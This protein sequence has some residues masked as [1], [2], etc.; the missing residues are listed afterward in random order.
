MKSVW[1]DEWLTP[2]SWRSSAREVGAHG[3]RLHDRRAERDVRRRVLVEERVVED[4]PGLRR[5][6]SGRRRARPRRGARRRRRSR[7]AC[8]S[9]PRPSSARTSTARPPSKRTSRPRTIV[10]LD[11]ERQRRAHGALDA[12]G[13]GGREDLLGRHVRDVLD[14]A[15]TRRAPPA[16]RD[17]GCRPIVRSVPGPAV[18]EVVERAA[19]SALPR[20]AASR[21]DVLAPGGDG[22]GLVEPDRRGRPPPRAARRRARRRPSAPS[23]RSGTRRSSSC[24]GR[25]SASAT[26]R[27]PRACAPCRR[28]RRRGRRRARARGCR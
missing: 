4:E 1:I 27:R 17:S 18:A 26:P 12:A 16:T 21:V 8:A 28:A 20:A 7:R 13:V 10:P 19:R 25:R 5:R 6:A 24:R 15:A 14:P 9:P 3:D 11:L 23:P 2:R 22:V